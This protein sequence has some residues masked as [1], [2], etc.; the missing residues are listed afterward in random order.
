MYYITIFVFKLKVTYFFFC[1]KFVNWLLLFQW[2][3][4]QDL[5]DVISSSGVTDIIE[6]K[7]HENRTNGQSKG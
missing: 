3:S 4:D 1:L 7:F 2:T 5:I 6:I